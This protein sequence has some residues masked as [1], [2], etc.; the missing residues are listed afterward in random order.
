VMEPSFEPSRPTLEKASAVDSRAFQRAQFLIREIP[1]VVL[2]FGESFTFDRVCWGR[3]SKLPWSSTSGE[4]A[5]ASSHTGGGHDHDEAP[6]RV[7]L[8]VF[9]LC[10][11]KQGLVC[12]LL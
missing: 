11:R 9:G 12:G 1:P 4:A 5:G 2:T 3:S 7:I 10:V 8:G 6:L